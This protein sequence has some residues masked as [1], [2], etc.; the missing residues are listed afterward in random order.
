MTAIGFGLLVLGYL[1]VNI[2]GT[3]GP[4]CV[5]T[6]DHVGAFLGMIGVALLVLGIAFWLWRVMP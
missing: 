3:G 4:R 2:F 5:S 6:A 1:I